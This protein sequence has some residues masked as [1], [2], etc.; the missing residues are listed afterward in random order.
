MQPSEGAGFREGGVYVIIGGSG[1]IGTILTRYLIRT[2]QAKVIW[3]GRRP[4]TDPALQE[5]IDACRAL[6]EPPTYIQAD[7][8]DARAVEQAHARIKKEYPAVHGAIFAGL[9]FDAENSVYITSEQRFRDILE[10]K[11]VG[12]L[13]FYNAFRGEPLDF[14]CFFSSGQ[15]FAFSGAANLSAYAT[16]ITFADAFV[17]SLHD[18]APF[19]MGIIN[20][21]FWRSS[22]N[23]SGDQPF[24]GSNIGCLEDEEGIACIERFIRC[25]RQGLLHQVLCLRA[26][27]SVR[28]LMPVVDDELVSL[29]EQPPS[30]RVESL[31][32]HIG[33]RGT[34]GLPND[35]DVAD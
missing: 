35:K 32:Q 27:D 24:S 1:I 16:G 34:D 12:S 17:R 4:G 33:Q 26:S 15:A 23:P 8:T 14:M 22:V 28:E 29:C 20:W 3:I 30:V 10:V 21:G 11:A 25:L 6:G 5:N 19:P 7:V 31:W 13:N 9:V 2:Y 18:Q